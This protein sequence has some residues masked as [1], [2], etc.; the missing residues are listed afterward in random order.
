MKE[1]TSRE[2]Q[3]GEL[4]VLKCLAK[5]CEEQNLRY[6]LFYGTLLG[7]VRHQGFIP[8]DDDID[9]IMPRPDYEKLMVYLEEH[10]EEIKPLK[11]MNNRNN[12]D[13]IYPI[14]RL[15]DTRY[16]VDYQ[17][18]KEYGLGL[19]VDIYPFDGCGNTPEEAHRIRMENQLLIKLAFTAGLATFQKSSKGILH[20]VVKFGA[21]CYAKL[22]G[23]GYFINKLEKNAAN[24]P[25][26]NDVFV[27]C[28]IWEDVDY[29]FR[30][31]MF[32]DFVYLPFEDAEFRVP[33][34]YDE[35]L[36]NNYGD[37]MKLPP[38][39]EQIGHHYYTAYLKDEE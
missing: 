11:L 19:F 25:F 32:D 1:L 2:V 10:A 27:N 29:Y 39:E 28:T 36:K 3:L 33:V 35:V 30:R 17:G 24:H 20:S 31:D 18:A 38:E 8:W 12:K 22:F 15:C 9:V 14:S 7:A 23:A 21:Y 4:S 6:F 13:Y 5:I 37:Y 16:H 26:D 34:N